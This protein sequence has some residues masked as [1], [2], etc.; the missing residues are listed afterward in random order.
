MAF[1]SNNLL[2]AD[3]VEQIRCQQHA[4]RTFVDDSFRLLPKT[5][6]LFHVAFNINWA[7]FTGKNLNFKLLETLKDELN[8]MVKSVDLP[9]YTV[10][11]EVLNQ[12]NR[13][14]VVQYQHKYSEAT[15]SF[16]DDNMGL[17]NQLWQAYYKYHYSDPNVASTK[18]AYSKNATKPSSFITSPYGYNGRIAPF[19]NYITLYQ[20]A[21]HEYVSY[22]LVNPVITSWSGGKVAYSEIGQSHSFEMKFAYEAVSYD[23]GFVDSGKMEGF[24]SAHYDWKT[25]PLT[26]DQ[27]VDVSTSPSF[28]RTAGFGSSDSTSTTTA[29]SQRTATGVNPLIYQSVINNTSTGGLQTVAL[30]KTT[31]AANTAAA[32][33]QMLNTLVTPAN[34]RTISPDYANA[35]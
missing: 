12:Y 26:S 10:T 9:T 34:T 17:I 27:S 21:R 16:H 25:S 20:M 11:H 2:I 7:A 28:A 1:V 14:K 18:G 23:T 15:V 32:Q 8:L 4:A 22:K 6:F 30:P 33:V 13:K 19:F 35:L 24:G 29:S 3:P 5:K 31:A